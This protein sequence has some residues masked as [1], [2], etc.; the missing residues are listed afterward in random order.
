[1][2]GSMSNETTNEKCPGVAFKY[3]DSLSYDGH[4]AEN[5]KT[6]NVVCNEVSSN[7]YCGFK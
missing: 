6:T 1:M 2:V 7:F 5:G 3:Y 4:V